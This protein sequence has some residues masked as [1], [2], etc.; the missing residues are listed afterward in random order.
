MAFLGLNTWFK[1]ALFLGYMC[2]WVSQ[3]MLVYGSKDARGSLPYNSTTVVMLSSFVKL[4]IATTMYLRENGDFAQMRAQ[5]VDNLGV[6][7]LYFVPAL[8]YT[9]YDNL[10]FVNLRFFDPPTYFILSQFRLVVTG[11][12]YQA[13]FARRLSSM[14]W[15]SLVVLTLGCIVKELP[16]FTG[17][18]LVEIPYL[19][20]ALIGVQI[21]SATFAGVYNEVLLKGKK[22][23]VNL[24]NVFMYVNSI[25]CNVLVLALGVHGHSLGE[26][27]EWRHLKQ[28]LRPLVLLII[29][30]SASMGIVTS[31]FLKHL[32]SVLKAIA[33]ALEI[34]LTA[35]VSYLIFGTDL[36]VF[37]VISMCLVA[38]GV[39]LYSTSPL[40][41]TQ[42][43][44]GATMELPTKAPLA[45]DGDAEGAGDQAALLQGGGTKR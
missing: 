29:L 41:P 35:V 42:P 3:G 18:G 12:V 33:S 45:R 25:F 37:T 44:P 43:K 13:L 1:Q 15:I 7:A 5:A 24:Q 30:N 34:V 10:T 4:G 19:S 31:L 26:A 40:P 11:V 14:Q 2:L 16:K 32:S 17:S 20:W 9:L 28:V 39:Y 22:L 8:L 23:P 36:G 27:F 6:W 38:F 21:L